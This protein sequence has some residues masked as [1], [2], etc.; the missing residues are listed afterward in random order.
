MSYLLAKQGTGLTNTTLRHH[1]TWWTC[2]WV[3]S[4]IQSHILSTPNYQYGNS[5]TAN[6]IAAR[7]S[8]LGSMRSQTTCIPT[9][10]VLLLP[11]LHAAAA[12]RS[13]ITSHPRVRACAACGNFCE[14]TTADNCER[15]IYTIKYQPNTVIAIFNGARAL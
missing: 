5:I 12:P 4:N 15:I 1:P 8:V 11:Y 7:G 3:F 6:F 10:H 9:P 13:R 14:Y 2:A